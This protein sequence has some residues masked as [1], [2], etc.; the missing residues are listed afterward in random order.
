VVDECRHVG[1]PPGFRRSAVPRSEWTNHVRSG[2]PSGG[3]RRVSTVSAARHHPRTDLHMIGDLDVRVADPEARAPQPAGRAD[4][5][6]WA[7]AAL[8][9]GTVVAVDPAGLVPTG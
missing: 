8:I 7:L 6:A 4:A 9:V 1:A 5:L 2:E 3:P